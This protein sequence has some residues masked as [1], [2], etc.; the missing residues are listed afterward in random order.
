M[1]EFQIKLPFE[2]FE[3]YK[4]MYNFTYYIN[5]QLKF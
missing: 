2:T 4:K 1:R 3:N 5:F